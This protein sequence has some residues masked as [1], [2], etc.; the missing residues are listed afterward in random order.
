MKLT[1]N[2]SIENYIDEHCKDELKVLD[3]NGNRLTI[4][5]F[6][7]NCINEKS[8]CRFDEKICPDMASFDKISYLSR[9]LAN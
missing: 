8:S 1:T 2:S 7:Q 3:K 6:I 5:Q 9:I 4:R